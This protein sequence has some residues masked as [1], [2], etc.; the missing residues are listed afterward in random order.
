MNDIPY[1]LQLALTVSKQSDFKIKVGCVIC[2]N[3]TPISVGY[4]HFYSDRHFCYSKSTTIHA[5]AMAIKNC[6]LKQ[7]NGAVIYVARMSKNGE[8]AMARP[9]PQCL[10]LLQKVGVKKMTYSIRGGYSQERI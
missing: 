10:V 8:L 3:G 6:S 5:E 4:N 2:R 7:L 9:C 1:F